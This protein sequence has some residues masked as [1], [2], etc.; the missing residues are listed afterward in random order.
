M[1]KAFDFLVFIL[2]LHNLPKIFKGNGETWK[3]SE[4]ISGQD[5]IIFKGC[6]VSGFT[7]FHTFQL[8]I[9]SQSR[10]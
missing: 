10:N 2:E 8:W 7:D 9:L 6:G 5:K 4:W 1:H 3:G